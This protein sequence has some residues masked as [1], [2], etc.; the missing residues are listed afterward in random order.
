MKKLEKLQ[1]AKFKLATE[2]LAKTLGGYKNATDG[3]TGECHGTGCSRQT[4]T[5]GAIIDWEDIECGETN[6]KGDPCPA[7]RA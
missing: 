1:N 7:V 4:G 2:E 5:S 3:D 6:V